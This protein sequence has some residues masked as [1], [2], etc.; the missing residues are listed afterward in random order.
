MKPVN[1]L[2]VFLIPALTVIG[3]LLQGSWVWLATVFV[4]GLVPLLEL[5]LPAPED[6]PDEEDF[7]YIAMAH[8]EE[9][10]FRLIKN[11]F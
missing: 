3:L 4:F 2:F 10:V 9:M 5:V 7:I 8:N 1:Y 11:L 6:N